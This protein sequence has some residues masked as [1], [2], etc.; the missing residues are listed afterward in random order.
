M[1]KDL[2]ENYIEQSDGQI[3]LIQQRYMFGLNRV[4]MRY[5]NSEQISNIQWLDIGSNMGYG[6]SSIANTVDII[7]SDIDI[8]Y[9]QSND[10]DQISKVVL[11][12]RNLPFKSN[13][14][15]VISCFETIEHIPLNEVEPTLLDIHRVL[16]EDG[17][18]LISTPNRVAN[19][20]IKMSTDH[21]QEF[22]PEELSYILKKNGFNIL[23][24]YGQNFIKKDNILHEIFLGLRENEFV[25][26][27]Y[28]YFPPSIVKKIRD[29]SISAFGSGEVRSRKKNELE[30]I[31]YFVCKKQPRY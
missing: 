7:A 9:L 4:E 6:V 2:F 31:I 13:T 27:L 20:N 8:R 16:K 10:E 1:E 11:N 5:S 12:S 14:L 21:K 26:K 18:F 17:I 24:K 30:R 19:G 28:Y 29:C 23:E 3:E 25:R 22:S 15:N